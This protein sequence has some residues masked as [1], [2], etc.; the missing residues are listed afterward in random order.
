[1]HMSLGS[2]KGIRVPG[3]LGWDF[4][5]EDSRGIPVRDG[6]QHQKH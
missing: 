5:L 1:M 4:L 3:V 6:G 2:P